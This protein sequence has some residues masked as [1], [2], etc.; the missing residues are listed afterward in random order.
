MFSAVQLQ[1]VPAKSKDTLHATGKG[2]PIIVV[3]GYAPSVTTL[4]DGNVVTISGTY[5]FSDTVRLPT[6]KSFE[7]VAYNSYSWTEWDRLS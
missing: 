4:P 7:T 1:P 6:D 5:P 3:S 2:G